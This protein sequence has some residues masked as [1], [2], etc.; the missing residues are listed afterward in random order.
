M[1]Q[2]KQKM[3]RCRFSI[4]DFWIQMETLSEFIWQEGLLSD[5]Q[6]NLK[7]ERYTWLKVLNYFM[8][9]N[10]KEDLKLD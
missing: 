3:D 5:N 7:K 4:L 10:Q 1:V 8:V 6:E 2:K 9:T